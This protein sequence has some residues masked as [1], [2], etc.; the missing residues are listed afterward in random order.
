[1]RLGMR[2]AHIE[3][4]ADIFEDVLLKNNA[5]SAASLKANELLAE[6]DTFGSA[7]RRGEYSN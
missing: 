6:F 4:P 3:T 5:D 7:S 1:M 2:D